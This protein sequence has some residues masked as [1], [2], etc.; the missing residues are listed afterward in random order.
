MQGIQQ[1]SYFEGTYEKVLF[2]ELEQLEK[3]NLRL[4]KVHEDYHAPDNE[5]RL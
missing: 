1:Q 5:G 2:N 3:D 4:R